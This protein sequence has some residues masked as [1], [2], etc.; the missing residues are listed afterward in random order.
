MRIKLIKTVFEY[1][2]NVQKKL[3]FMTVTNVISFLPV[4]ERKKQI[5]SERTNK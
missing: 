3:L 2:C 1:I 4:R 5:K